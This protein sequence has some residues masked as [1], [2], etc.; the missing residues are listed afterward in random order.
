MGH[1]SK[2]MSDR[3]DRVRDDVVFRMEVARRMGTGFEV[4]KTLT[5][6]APKR[7]STVSKISV[8][9]VI[10]REAELATT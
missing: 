5:P 9:G 8:S 6:K 3:Y 4:P 2:D 10:G 7:K 1:A